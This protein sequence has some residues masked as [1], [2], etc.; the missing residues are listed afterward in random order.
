MTRTRQRSTIIAEFLLLL[1]LRSEQTRSLA[2][3]EQC[4]DIFRPHQ[5]C[6]AA[7][8]M[9][10][11]GQTEY[12]EHEVP[13]NLEEWWEQTASDGRCASYV[14]ESF[15]AD[16][17]AMVEEVGQHIM[18]NDREV[19]NTSPEFLRG[20][21]GADETFCEPLGTK[22]IPVERPGLCWDGRSGTL[23]RFTVMGNS[24]SAV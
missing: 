5:R 10:T 3:P 11:D 9:R 1:L 4:I 7:L 13:I 18:F 20:L 16:E 2:V 24:H 23:P 19:W 8:C 15:A 22:T 14:W 21:L 17:T 6:K 12:F